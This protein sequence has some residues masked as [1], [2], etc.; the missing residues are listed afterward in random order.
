M[1]AGTAVIDELVSALP[2]GFTAST[3]DDHC[4]LESLR[5]R[6]LAPTSFITVNRREGHKDMH[7]EKHQ[8]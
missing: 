6:K 8:S 7:S 1:C 2:I 4:G 5:N 3:I